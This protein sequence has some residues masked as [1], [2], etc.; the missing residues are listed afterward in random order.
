VFAVPGHVTNENPWGPN[1]LIKQGAKLVATW[2][3]VWEEL[4]AD[5]RQ[6]LSP[7]P[8]ESSAGQTASLFQGSSCRRMRKGCWRCSRRPV[9][10]GRVRADGWDRRRAGRRAGE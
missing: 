2:E 8:A 1:T 10:A 9:H 6:H 5:I 7:T 4:H 3:D